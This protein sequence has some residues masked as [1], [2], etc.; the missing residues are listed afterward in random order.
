MTEVESEVDLRPMR[1]YSSKDAE[2]QSFI[3][4]SVTGTIEIV[5]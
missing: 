4:G 2:K 3:K 1:E 5:R